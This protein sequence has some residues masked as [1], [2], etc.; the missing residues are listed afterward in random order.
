MPLALIFTYTKII[1]IDRS[2]LEITFVETCSTFVET[3]AKFVETRVTI[4]ET[5]TTFVK[6][7]ATF[8]GT[9]AKFVETSATLVETRARFVETRTTFVE[10]CED[11]W[12]LIKL[13][14]CC[15]IEICVKFI[16]MSKG[17]LNLL[18]LV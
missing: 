7:G 4:V 11:R 8:V 1:P 12:I 5:S 3:R 2:I 6:N 13:N 9:S 15:V 14:V 10:L 18:K 16:L 17:Q